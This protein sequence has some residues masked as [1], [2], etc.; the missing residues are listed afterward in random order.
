MSISHLP[1]EM[2]QLVDLVAWQ[3]SDAA[4][5]VP[6]GPRHIPPRTTSV[7]RDKVPRNWSK[8]GGSK[9]TRI[10]GSNVSGIS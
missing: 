10:D 2:R 7:R 4:A 1:I 9:I 5:R 3:G 6:F 8:N